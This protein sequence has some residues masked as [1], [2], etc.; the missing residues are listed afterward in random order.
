MSGP[1]GLPGARSA[2]DVFAAHVVRVRLPG[3]EPGKTHRGV[4]RASD[5]A[6]DQQRRLEVRFISGLRD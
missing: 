4:R 2:G 3:Q 1:A 6:G 5:T